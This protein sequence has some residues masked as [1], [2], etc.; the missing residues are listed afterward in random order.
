MKKIVAILFGLSVLVYGL[1]L[2]IFHDPQTTGFYIL[3]DVAFLPISIAIATIVVGE[4][5][6]EREKRERQEKTQM[7]ASSFFTELGSELLERLMPVIQ[8]GD[9]MREIFT[10]CDIRDNRSLD[11]AREKINALT[12]EV[13]L[14]KES[15][16]S[17][18]ELITERR[19]VLLVYSS[20]PYL[21]DHADFTKLIWGLY[22]LLDESRLRKSF[23]QMHA[24]EI[25]HLEN[26]FAEVI[27]LVIMNLARNLLYMRKHYPNYYQTVL[28][29]LHEKHEK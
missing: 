7:M 10:T 17:L 26:D 9:A 16:D 13:K 28:A 4:F 12:L 5:F 29:S 25:E 14:E 8:N 20:S 18:V 15:Y 6:S 1:Q 3:Q 19:E 23:D 21:L 2:L 11:Q 27:K 22:H 24:E